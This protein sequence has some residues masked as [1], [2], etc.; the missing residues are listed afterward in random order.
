[1]QSFMEYINKKLTED[2]QILPTVS[3]VPKKEV[4]KEIVKESVEAKPKSKQIKSD[5]SIAK[6]ILDGVSEEIR[7]Y[8]SSLF[9]KEGNTSS[10]IND[11][12]QEV[13]FSKNISD[14]SKHAG[15][16]LMD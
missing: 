3:N 15:L 1:M 5:V 10:Y 4:K 13:V 16:L 11:A 8:S 12:G 2:K 7:P 14:D 9:M 6:N